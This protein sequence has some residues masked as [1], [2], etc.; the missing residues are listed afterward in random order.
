MKKVIFISAIFLGVSGYG[1]AQDS[2][3]AAAVL[4]SFMTATGGSGMWYQYQTRYE[5]RIRGTVRTMV[6]TM[7]SA[8]SDDRYA[9]V[10]M[11]V[12]GMRFSMLK[13]VGQPR[14]TVKLNPQTKSYS[15]TVIDTAW[16]N[17]ANGQTFRVVRIGTES[18]EGYTCVHAKMTVTGADGKVVT[19]DDLWTSTAVPEYAQYKREMADE[20][21]TVKMMQALE[22][23][24]CEGFVVKIVGETPMT[25]G[26][27]AA[28]GGGSQTKFEMT[29]IKAERRN[30]PASMFEIPAGYTESAVAKFV[31]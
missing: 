22:K 21:I 13:H 20:H 26:G 5:V 14:Y 27:A 19:T 18:V 31:K 1:K 2:A 30:F 8:I 16:S 6:D 10:D 25:G 9:H 29:L 23:A 24:G 28:P 3:D 17:S 4:K 11:G 12:W 7:S 15:L